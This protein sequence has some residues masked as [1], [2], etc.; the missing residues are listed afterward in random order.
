MDRTSIGGI[1]KQLMFQHANSLRMK[2]AEIMEL[3]SR[4][5]YRRKPPSFLVPESDLPI[6]ENVT[7]GTWFARDNVYNF[8]KFCR[9]LQVMEVV[10]FETEDLVGQ[11]NEKHVILTLLE[12]ARK[13]AKIGMLAPMLV[14]FEQEIDQEL[15]REEKERKRRERE[16]KERER[17]LREEEKARKVREREEERLRKEKEAAKLIADSEAALQKFQDDLDLFPSLAVEVPDDTLMDDVE[18]DFHDGYDNDFDEYDEEIEE[19]EEEEEDEE[20]EEEGYPYPIGPMP[21][22]VTNDLRSLDEMVR[23]MVSECQC[24]SQFPMIRV[25]EGKYKIGETRVL[26]FVRVSSESPSSNI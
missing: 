3:F 4:G 21:Q 24:P 19:E 22:E 17:Q 12:V 6:R 15:A 26:I 11:K 25:S 1:I 2:H 9:L 23:D 7:P 8:I 14:Q 16:E 10:M 18:D 5:E 13:G 20:E